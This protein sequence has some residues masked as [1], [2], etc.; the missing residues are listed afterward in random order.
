MTSTESK[1]G[2]L[3]RKDEK[4]TKRIKEFLPVFAFEGDNF[5]AS[6]ADIRVDIKRLPE[7]INRAWPRHCTD[8]EQDAN[9]WLE[10]RAKGVEEP[11]MGV[12]L[13]LIFLFET[14][15]DLHGHNAFLRAFELVRRRNGDCG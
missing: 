4:Q 15:D 14:E 12:D 13:F 9:I 3:A 10:N 1:G 5:A 7:M 6:A 2:R 11:T 8:I